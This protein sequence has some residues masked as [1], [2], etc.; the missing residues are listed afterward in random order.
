MSLTIYPIGVERPISPDP[1]DPPLAGCVTD[2]CRCGAYNPFAPKFLPSYSFHHPVVQRIKLGAV[3][4][5]I[6]HPALP[7][8]R[9]YE[10]DNIMQKLPEEHSQQTTTCCL[11]TRLLVTRSL[12]WVS[13]R[14]SAD[15]GSCRLQCI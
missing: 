5:G 7:T 13:D 15:L 3:K 10:M 11:G 2:P 12:R 8:L 9:R 6:F 1:H 14:Y 4:T